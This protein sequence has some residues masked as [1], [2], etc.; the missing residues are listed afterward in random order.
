ME[1]T[2]IQNVKNTH[3]TYKELMGK[4]YT[5]LQ[6]NYDTIPICIKNNWTPR[7]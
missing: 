7:E 3:H 5:C 2:E 6:A 1:H 4:N